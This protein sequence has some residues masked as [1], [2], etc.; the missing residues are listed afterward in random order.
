MIFLLSPLETLPDFLFSLAIRFFMRRESF[1][2][3][4][5]L[6]VLQ[7]FFSSFLRLIHGHAGGA[8]TTSYD[9]INFLVISSF[10][11]D[12]LD[13]KFIERGFCEAHTKIRKFKL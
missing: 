11:S 12:K 4:F 13:V 3:S 8:N 7:S 9:I 5:V 6:F 10:G 2:N 1:R